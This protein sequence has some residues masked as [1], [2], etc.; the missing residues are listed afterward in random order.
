MTARATATVLLAVAAFAAFAQEP[1]KKY[2]PR[3]ELKRQAAAARQTAAAKPKGA[4]SART[5]AAKS[6]A[7]PAETPYRRSPYVG[8]IAVD[9]S[10][11]RLLFADNAQAKAYPA[12][13]TKLMTAYLVLEEVRAGRLSLDDEVVASPVRNRADAYARQPSCIGLKAGESMSVDSMLKA[14]LVHSANDAAVFLAERCAGS[15]DAFVERMNAKAA[16]LGMAST[17]Y[18]NPNG[19]PPPPNAKE[20]NFNF[21]TCE[22]QAKLAIAI[23]SGCPE[24]LRYTSMKTLELTFPNGNTQKF[25]NHN[26][27]MVKN[28]LKVMNPDGTEAVDGLKTGYID[29]GGS[30]V[31]LTGKRD[32]HRVVVVVLG[33]TSGAERDEAAATRMSD[34]LDAVQL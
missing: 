24:I 33:S 22:D 27:V 32:G 14:L 20:R 31:V 23:L 4:A 2:P 9:A 3:S 16:A 12:S 13:V 8:A 18:F 1:Q 10:N 30:S 15:A 29:A 28:K 19:L 11:G 26:N 25:V 21:S 5:S 6:A 17:R 7:A 34:A